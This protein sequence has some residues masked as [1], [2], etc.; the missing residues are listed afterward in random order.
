[1]ST[2]I[3]AVKLSSEGEVLWSST[4]GGL[5][6]KACATDSEGNV[7]VSGEDLGA[8]WDWLT[9]KFDPDGNK[10]WEATEGGPYSDSPRA[11]CVDVEDNIYV[12]GTWLVKYDK[13]GN[14]IWFDP[15]GLSSIY[16]LKYDGADAL[17]MQ[18]FESSSCEIIV[19]CNLDGNVMWQIPSIGSPPSQA[20]ELAVENTDQFYIAGDTNT[21]DST[22]FT[23]KYSIINNR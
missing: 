7:I 12:G 5:Y 9:I 4:G 21:F 20:F 15:E 17:Y 1:M 19:K 10:L 18:I 3:T 11:I 23:A 2:S 13:D 6:G 16:S 22:G 14:Q 8:D